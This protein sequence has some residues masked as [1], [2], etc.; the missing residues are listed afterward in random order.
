MRGNFSKEKL[1]EL[2]EQYVYD[3]HISKDTSPRF[4][5]SISDDENIYVQSYTVDGSSGQLLFVWEATSKKYLTNPDFID[6]E[7]FKKFILLGWNQN[8]KDEN[9]SCEV[10]AKECLDGT[11]A[12]LL[13]DSLCI[14][15]LPL[16]QIDVT[17]DVS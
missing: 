4:L 11:V 9:F 16:S 7:R 13:Y 6:K 15:D 17:W 12:E 2:L 10:T 5:Y 8:G 3:A 14:F 1:Q